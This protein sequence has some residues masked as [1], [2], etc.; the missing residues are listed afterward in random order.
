MNRPDSDGDDALVISCQDCV[1]QH[2]DH[3]GDC[4]VTF[5]CDERTEQPVVVEA[6]EAQIVDLLI[7]AGLVPGLRQVPRTRGPQGER[8]R[9]LR[10]R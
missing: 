10:S 7:G 5:F 9:M 2:T 6:G 4:V 1:M 3:C 8:A